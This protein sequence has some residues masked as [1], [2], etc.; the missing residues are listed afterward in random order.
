VNHNSSGLLVRTPPI[1]YHENLC[2][3]RNKIKKKYL[4]VPSHKEDP[5][6]GQTRWARYPLLT[7]NKIC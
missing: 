1:F 6:Y 7:Q 2:L 4:H 3:F 5:L